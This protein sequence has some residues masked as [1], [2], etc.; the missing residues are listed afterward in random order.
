MSTHV[1]FPILVVTTLGVPAA[2]A[3]NDETECRL[4]VSFDKPGAVTAWRAVNDNVMGGR[5]RG[6]PGY[7]DGAL[8]FSGSIDT[9][10][11][12]F[13]SIRAPLEPGVLAGTSSLKLRVRPDDRSY[14]VTLRTDRRYRGMEV[15]WRAVIDAPRPGEW[16]DSIVRFADLEPAVRG[17]R[18]A[19]GPFEPAAA[20]SIGII[21]SDGRDGPFELSVESIHACVF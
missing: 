5:S 6:G 15:A 12:G 3:V 4:L 11:G 13:S 1:L 20:T 16:T 7:G 18:I 21:I 14:R 2:V 19:A 8:V 9:D 17:R 10:G